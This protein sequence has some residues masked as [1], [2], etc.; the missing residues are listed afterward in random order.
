MC[1]VQELLFPLLYFL[2]YAPLIFFTFFQKILVRPITHE[3]FGIFSLNFIGMYTRS[4]LCVAYNYCCSHFLRFRVMAIWLFLYL[5]CVIYILVHST[6]HS[7]FMIS[8]EFVKT[9]CR[10][11]MIVPPF[12]VSNL[13]PFDI[14]FQ[15][16]SRT[17]RNPVIVW[18]IFMELHRNVYQVKTM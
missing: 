2:S 11:R 8:S 9:M 5:H 14:F 16:K 1:H 18:D 4:R 15:K 13:C 3:L 12:L 7:L 10:A 17:T 6:T